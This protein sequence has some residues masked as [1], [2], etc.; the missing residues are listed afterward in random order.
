MHSKVCEW[1]GHVPESLGRDT[2]SDF[3]SESFKCTRCSLSYSVNQWGIDQPRPKIVVYGFRL[4]L[5][6]GALWFFS[7]LV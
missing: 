6:L 1:F 7:V 5:L 2:T 4:L 3:P